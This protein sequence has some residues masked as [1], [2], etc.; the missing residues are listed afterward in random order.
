MRPGLQSA[1]KTSHNNRSPTQSHLFLTGCQSWIKQC[2]W[3]WQLYLCI[4]IISATA[5]RVLN[6]TNRTVAYLTIKAWSTVNLAKRTHSAKWNEQDESTH[7]RFK[8]KLTAPSKW[9]GQ[10]QSGKSVGRGLAARRSA[11]PA[12]STLRERPAP[13][14][15][16]AAAHTRHR[17]PPLEALQTVGRKS[18]TCIQ[19]TK[20]QII[21]QYERVLDW[22][23]KLMLNYFIFYNSNNSN[24]YFIIVEHVL[25][26]LYQIR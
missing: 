3:I 26:K 4:T 16:G 17:A 12:L 18:N 9:A 1:L 11:G 14:G 2:V 19:K 25:I 8:G 6:H 22:N 10:W 21:L 15:G 5:C 23:Y 13:A 20:K 7:R 24:N